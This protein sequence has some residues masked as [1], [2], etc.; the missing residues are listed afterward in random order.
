MK[1]NTDM[2]KQT[3]KAEAGFTLVELAIV[4]IIIGLLIGGV[5]K[6]Q[7][8]IGNAQVTAAAAQIKGVD[9]AVTTF[10]D[11]YN[12]LPG[13]VVAPNTRLPGCA[14]APCSQTG[15]GD[16]RLTNAPSNVAPLITDENVTFWL[17]LAAADLLT[18]V[19]KSAGTVAFDDGEPASK[20]GGG[21]YYIGYTPGGTLADLPNRSTAQAADIGGG[22]WLSLR[23]APTVASGAAGSRI[24]SAATTARVDRKL[25]DGLPNTG[26]LLAAGSTAGAAVDCTNGTAAVSPY[27]EANTGKTCDFYVRIQQ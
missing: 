2:I 21:G 22:H 18:G 25:D 19:N 20:I 12:A 4:M 11:Q 13:D 10:R 14:A 3:R 24:L 9:A 23:S 16:G 6:G 17:H 15:N 27:M 5:L 1:G 8:L 26:S 7:A